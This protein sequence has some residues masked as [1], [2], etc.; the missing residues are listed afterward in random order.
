MSTIKTNTLTGTTSAGVINVTGEGGSNT[1]NLQNG[2]AKVRCRSNQ[3]NAQYA[4]IDSFN[5]TSLT[6]ESGVGQS[7]MSF[8][9]N[10]ENTT[11][12]YTGSCGDEGIGATNNG[13]VL[14]LEDNAQTTSTSGNVETLSMS[15]NISVDTP[16]VN[17]MAFGDL[18]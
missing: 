13:A 1:T 10:F 12:S 5:I 6:D 17:Y 7:T 3:R 2:L 18:A 11:F 9:A 4:V 16:I 14:R 8:T 15:T